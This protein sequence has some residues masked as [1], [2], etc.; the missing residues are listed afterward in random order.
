[1]C[2]NLNAHKVT[3]IPPF[4]VLLPAEKRDR[5]PANHH[6]ALP[7]P[8]HHQ[9]GTEWVPLHTDASNVYCPDGI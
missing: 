2:L 4:R 7:H 3:K 1:M 6:H 9:A 5:L 8:T